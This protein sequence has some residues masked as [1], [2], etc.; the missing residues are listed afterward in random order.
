LSTSSHAHIPRAVVACCQRYTTTHS[1]VPINQATGACSHFS[2]LHL[3]IFSEEIEGKSLEAKEASCW[4]CKIAVGISIFRVKKRFFLFARIRTKY[5]KGK[6][7]TRREFEGGKQSEPWRWLLD[8]RRARQTRGHGARGKARDDWCA[9][10]AWGQSPASGGG[11]DG[12]KK[13]L[14]TARR[15]HLG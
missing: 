15:R 5:S 4:L 9:K 2:V 8:L 13:R 10:C 12:Q 1:G 11:G 7:K 14:P 6:G 3:L